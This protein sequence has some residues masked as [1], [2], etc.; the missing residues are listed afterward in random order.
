MSANFE[1]R[2][3]LAFKAD[4]V[5][6]SD[7]AALI[8]ETEVAAANAN[9]AATKAREQALDPVVSPDAAKARTAMEDAAFTRDRLRTVLPRLQSRLQQVH[10]HERYSRWLAE[11]ERVRPRH[12]AAVARLKTVYLEFEN[13]LVDALNEAQ[14]VDAEVKRLG[15]VKPYDEPSANGDGC[16]LLTVEIAARGITEIGLYGHSIMK[17]LK[18]PDFSEPTKLAWPPPTPSLAVQVAASMIQ[19]PHLGANW[20]SERE[21]RAQAVREEHERVIAHYDA[22]TRAQEEREAAEA[23]KRGKGA[24]A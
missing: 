9:E 21:E 6:S 15:S 5:N 19:R 22:A 3:A 8:E 17:D 7:L 23:Q 12:D 1:Y 20:A 18:L 4:D 14:E 13:K 16:N 11:F 24:V 2:I 10:L